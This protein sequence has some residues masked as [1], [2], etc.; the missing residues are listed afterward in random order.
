MHLIILQQLRDCLVTL[1]NLQIQQCH[2]GLARYWGQHHLRHHQW[3]RILL[4][5]NILD[6]L[7]FLL[8]LDCLMMR[9]CLAMYLVALLHRFQQI[10]YNPGYLDFLLY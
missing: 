3:L 8:H 6:C 4:S 2:F 1:Q 7:H 5:R 9:L 10:L